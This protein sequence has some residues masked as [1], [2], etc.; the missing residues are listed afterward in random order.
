[1]AFGKKKQ[2]KKKTSAKVDVVVQHAIPAQ[3]RALTSSERL[4]ARAGEMQSRID[5]EREHR[6]GGLPTKGVDMNALEVR[7]AVYEAGAAIVKAL[8][9]R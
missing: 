2:T 3:E 9:K 5:K 1:M 8:E 6:K 4:E 7:K